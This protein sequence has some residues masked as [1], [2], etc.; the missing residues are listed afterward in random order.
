MLT[1]TRSFLA[2]TLFVAGL[3][4]YSCAGSE[5]GSP[6]S[7]TAVT[8]AS[9]G[10]ATAQTETPGTSSGFGMETRPADPNDG[11]E[12]APQPVPVPPAPEPPPTP[13]APEPPPAPPAP[14]PPPAPPA[15]PS[16]P[17]PPPDPSIP[18]PGPPTVGGPLTAKID[19]DP[20]P[21][22]GR[23][24]PLFSCRDLQHTWFYEQ[25]LHSN[26]GAFAITITERENFFDGRFVNKV[27]E[28]LNV[29]PN[30]TVRFQSRWCSGYPRAHTAQTVFK[31]HDGNNNPITVFGPVVRLLAR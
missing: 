3:V 10:R 11:H 20:V 7:P 6:T 15:P 22:S 28:T 17:G 1:P 18:R 13:P 31:G 29:G 2:A 16:P 8:P 30:G 27:R 9:G 19:P 14:E 23:R 4:T 26:T 12:P 24:I 21:Y 25:I 5:Q